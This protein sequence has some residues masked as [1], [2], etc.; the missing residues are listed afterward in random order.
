M[1]FYLKG[2]VTH[3]TTTGKPPNARSYLGVTKAKIKMMLYL[4][5]SNYERK[6]RALFGEMR[7]QQGF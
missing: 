3:K 5:S 1:M 2:G 7:P 4:V 6:Y